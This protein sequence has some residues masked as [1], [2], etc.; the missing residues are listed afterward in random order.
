MKNHAFSCV[1]LSKMT[2]AS[3]L[4]TLFMASLTPFASAE[5]RWSLDN[6]VKK[7][8]VKQAAIG[9]AAGAAGGALS[10]RASIGKGAF[11]GALAGAGTGL[12]SQSRYFND[13][14]LIKNTVQGAIVGTGASYALGTN[15]LK[16]AAVGAGGGAGYH[17][18]RRYLDDQR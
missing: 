4:L 3:L 5:D 7:P 17:Y 15:K 2:L 8:V 12:V 9:A 18:I 6:L 1:S 13:K 14:P 10:D 11:A 16:G